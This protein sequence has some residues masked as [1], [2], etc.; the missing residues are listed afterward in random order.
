MLTVLDYDTLGEQMRRTVPLRGSL[1]HLAATFK[2]TGDHAR[3][4]QRSDVHDELLL[5]PEAVEPLK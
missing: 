4:V 5:F 2:L 3:P 1:F